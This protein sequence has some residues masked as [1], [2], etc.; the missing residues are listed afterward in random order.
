MTDERDPLELEALCI[1]TVQYLN[2]TRKAPV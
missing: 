2:S 1:H